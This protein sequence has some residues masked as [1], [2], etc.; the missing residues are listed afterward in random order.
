MTLLHQSNQP[1]TAFVLVTL[2]VLLACAACDTPTPT[3]P[4][5]PT[6]S[7]TPVPVD[8]IVNLD[9]NASFKEFIDLLPA[10]TA[11]CLLGELGQGA[12]SLIL[13][14]SVFSD[15]F[16]FDGELPLA[17]F[18]Q[19][20]VIS[21]VIARLGQAAGGLS[22]DTATCIRETFGGLDVSSLAAITSGDLSGGSIDDA[23]GVGIGLLLCLND[24]EASRITAGGL[25]GDIGGASDISVAD[26]RCV[27]QVVDISELM[28]LVSSFDSRAAPD[29]STSLSLLNAFNDCGINFADFTGGGASDELGDLIDG[30]SDSNINLIGDGTADSGALPP[31]DLN[32]LSQLPPEL[33]EPIKCLVGGIGEDSTNGLVA[34]T[35]T[36]TL[37]DFS[38]TSACN[39]GLAEAREADRLAS[40]LGG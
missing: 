23:L 24:D 9:E 30:G 34:G 32:D 17:C 4:H 6:P 2:A 20:A 3:P 37:P 18:D 12:Y 33:Q 40:I 36:P 39:I 13:S 19:G 38:T 15:D 7:P 8:P 14:Q 10:D 35:Y 11:A 21:L 26:V 27:L 31:L 22:S 5:T 29:L 1:F 25:F 16:D 28:G